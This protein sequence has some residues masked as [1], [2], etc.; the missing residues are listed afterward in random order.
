MCMLYT[1]SP[2][3]LIFQFLR[4]NIS[5]V[6]STYGLT[7]PRATWSHASQTVATMGEYLSLKFS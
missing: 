7:Y 6:V 2:N 4:L 3:L 1:Q 5:I